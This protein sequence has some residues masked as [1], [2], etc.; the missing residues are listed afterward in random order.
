MQILYNTGAMNRF[1][2]I[3]RGL[4]LAMLVPTVAPA[5]TS[6]NIIVHAENLA[7][8][9]VATRLMPVPIYNFA[10]HNVAFSPDGR[11]LATGDGAGVVR[12]WETATGKLRFKIPAHTNWAFSVAWSKSGKFFATGGGDDLI[13]LFDSANPTAALKTF[14]GHDG[15]VH[16]VVITPDER[17]VASAG[18]DRQII[19]WDIKSGKPIRKRPA[20]EKAIPTLALSPNGKMLASGSRDHLIRLWNME[21]GRLRETLV[22]HT[23]DVLSVRFSPDGKW[24]AS[25][26]Y[27]QTV[28]LWDASSGKSLR[29]F[30]GHTNRVFGVAFSPDGKR[31]ASAG[32]SSLRI[33]DA[34]HGT[35]LK[36]IFPGGEIATRKGTVNGNISA[37]AF[38]PDGEKLAAS[39]TTGQIFLLSAN[40]GDVMRTFSEPASEQ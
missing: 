6:S 22:G 21:T 18:D 31:L 19:L 9:P 15:D 38:S 17:R 10:V 7:P 36:V 14:N 8:D 2:Q 30:Y 33:W 1:L 26:S 39:S 40:T 24:L 23:E 13:H 25:T 11:T 20:H 32:D 3:A 5:Q 16:A 28:R 35:E 4:G 37:V 29:I 27:D 34:L 12:L